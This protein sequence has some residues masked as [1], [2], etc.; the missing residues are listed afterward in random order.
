[1]AQPNQMNPMAGSRMA[2][3][4]R[5]TG[6][7]AP[8]WAYRMGLSTGP[9]PPGDRGRGS[10]VRL[11]SAFGQRGALLKP[12]EAHLHREPSPSS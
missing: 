9:R 1:M 5:G 3:A 4:D 12:V 7:P 11:A 2:Q 6:R 10:S 8:K